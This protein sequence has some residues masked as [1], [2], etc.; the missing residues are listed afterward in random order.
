MAPE[1][2]SIN[3]KVPRISVSHLRE[4]GSKKTMITCV[5]VANY[6]PCFPQMIIRQN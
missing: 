6:S 5:D 1:S 2:E 4:I 3:K